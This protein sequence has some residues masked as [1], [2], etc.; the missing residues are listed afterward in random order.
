M[1]LLYITMFPFYLPSPF[2]VPSWES[3]AVK[4][5]QEGKRTLVWKSEKWISVNVIR[6]AS[7]SS[8]VVAGF[9]LPFWT[10]AKPLWSALG[11]S[12][13][14]DKVF[15]LSRVNSESSHT[16]SLPLSLSH[17]VSLSHCFTLL[18]PITD[19]H[20]LEHTLPKCPGACGLT[21]RFASPN[22]IIRIAIIFTRDYLTAADVDDAENII[23][24]W[25][26]FFVYKAEI[27][28]QSFFFHC[29]WSSTKFITMRRKKL[30]CKMDKN[31]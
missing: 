4:L 14:K 18:R 9:T 6:V 28:S 7:S 2:F 16:H 31:F 1:L 22:F 3:R 26:S 27:V 11:E 30:F 13:I 10:T 19:K 23:K 17:T 12:P 29:V 15:S 24:F 20:P 5:W 21:H 8:V 25:E